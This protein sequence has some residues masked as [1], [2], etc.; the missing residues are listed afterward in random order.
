[1]YI[2][3]RRDT[4]APGRRALAA[5]PANVI[6]LGAVS[7][8]TDVSS[9]MVTAVLPLYLALTLGLT[10]L[11]LGFVDGL[12]FGVTALLRPAG[13]RLADRWRHKPV[14]AAG[15]ALSALAK[16]G[17]LAAGAAL[18]PLAA[19]IVADRTG[20]GLRTAPRDALISLS[21]PAGREGLAFGVH[22]AMDTVGAFLGPLAAF[23]VLAATGG[24]YRSV[25]AV[26]FCVAAFGLVLLVLYVRDRPGPAPAAPPVAAVLRDPSLR[27]LSAVAAGLGLFTLSDFFVYLLLQHS[28]A[29]PLRWFPLLPLGTAG[30]YLLLA[31]PLGRLADRVGRVRV[32]LGGHLALVAAMLLLAGTPTGA[33][34][35]A[36]VLL[37][38]GL[39]YAATDGVL[40]AL[41]GP[42]LPDASRA[43]GLA[44]V[45]T[46]QAAARFASSLAA[47]ALWAAWGA[48]TALLVLAAGLLAAVAAAARGLR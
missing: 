15:Y 13:G 35:L 31:V 40:M 34:L 6:A 47:G 26:S 44:V 33:P 27:R 37:L 7:L 2:T 25:F 5:V 10:P 29:V 38:H 43:T 20:K 22:R 12:S 48:P 41:A 36:A 11:Q 17:V 18:G 46:A 45:Q 14:A 32:L 1:M 21:A 3:M 8:V 4:P 9:E 16:V 39:F 28:G 24:V 23:A 42:L 19:A 30:V